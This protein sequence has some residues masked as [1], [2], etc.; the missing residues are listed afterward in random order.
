M[1][2][3][4]K[5]NSKYVLIGDAYVHGI[6]HGEYKENAPRTRIYEIE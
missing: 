3:R 4:R 5:S 1:I 6:M 2:L